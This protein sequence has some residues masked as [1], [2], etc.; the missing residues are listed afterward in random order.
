MQTLTIWNRLALALTSVGAV[1]ALFSP[2]AEADGATTII[3]NGANVFQIVVVENNINTII[4]VT[5][6]VQIC[7]QAGSC[8]I[9]QV[10]PGSAGGQNGG[11]GGSGGA[12]GTGGTGGS[13]GNGGAGG[14]PYPTGGGNGQTG[15]PGSGGGSAD[16]PSPTASDP[17][18]P[19]PGRI[20]GTVVDAGSGR[21]LAGATIAL[22]DTPMSQFSPDGGFV[23]PWVSVTS[24][25]GGSNQ[26]IVRLVSPPPGY[27]V[28]GPR[29]QVVAVQSGRDAWVTF[30]VKWS[31]T[32][33]QVLAKS[34][35]VW[36]TPD[37][38]ATAVETVA[39]WSYLR[40][41]APMNGTRLLVFDP[42]TNKTGYVDRAAL[43]PSGPPPASK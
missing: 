35:T 16:P 12:G 32:W 19:G 7:Q 22:A 6:I 34:T 36:S 9:T 29:Q 28:E 17:V 38:K 20:K 14:T 39:Q 33:T 18:L 2:A 4:N 42:R 37:A 11:T 8:N 25:Y 5:N 1:A 40:V 30:K 21:L 13:G 3:Q 43:G 23:F 26:Y 10:G 41:D 27:A 15:T 24:G 31:G